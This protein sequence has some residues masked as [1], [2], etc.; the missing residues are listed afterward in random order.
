MKTICLLI[1][2]LS[3]VFPAIS[4]SGE[5][6]AYSAGSLAVS[7]LIRYYSDMSYL[8]KQEKHL[9]QDSEYDKKLHF[10]LNTREKLTEI[11]SKTGAY[12]DISHVN[13]VMTRLYEKQGS[14]SGYSEPKPVARHNRYFDSITSHI[15]VKQ[16]DGTYF[17]YKRNGDFFKSAKS[18]QPHLATSRHI[19]PIDDQSYILYVKQSYHTDELRVLPAGEPHPEGWRFL[20]SLHGTGE[21]Y[22]ITAREK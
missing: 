12:R 2:G 8:S 16:Q 4:V 21:P 19:H 15:Y 6:P 20:D 11:I 5:N 3:L 17:E 13:Y 22:Q 18:D 7:H 14:V 9:F 10:I 1:F